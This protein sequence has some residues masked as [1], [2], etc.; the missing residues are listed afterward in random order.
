MAPLT[1]SPQSTSPRLSP[2][3]PPRPTPTTSTS[4]LPPPGLGF[5]TSGPSATGAGRGRKSSLSRN[6]GSVQS[7]RSAISQGLGVQ[8]SALELSDLTPSPKLRGPPS[9]SNSRSH[10]RRSS[11]TSPALQ[12]PLFGF[13]DGLTSPAGLPPTVASA[14]SA[15]RSSSRQPSRRP[16]L[17][18]L[19]SFLS[20]I[21][22]HT[23]V[24]SPGVTGGRGVSRS[25]S[26]SQ[27]RASDGR[28][29]STSTRSSN[30]RESDD[31]PDFDDL[32]DDYGFR[33]SSRRSS[34]TSAR[35]QLHS[36]VRENTT[37]GTGGSDNSPGSTPSALAERLSGALGLTST[38][39]PPPLPPPETRTFRA[40]S[41]PRVLGTS[42]DEEPYLDTAPSSP[43]PY[44]RQ[45]TRT[46][47]SN[48]SYEEEAS[49]MQGIDVFEEGERIGVGVWLE[50]RGGWI[51]DCFDEPGEEPGNGAGGPGVLE[52]ERRL[53]EGTYAM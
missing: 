29:A 28:R 23:R 32:D 49:G 24:R 50:E 26:R 45:R 41:T 16:S 4:P 42:A 21:E 22:H 19:A 47:D 44:F 14:V 18:H 2:S 48:D 30:D 31:E 38:P 6:N 11:I 34:L 43:Q 7:R 3:S 46:L 9:R 5:P 27:S 15:T 37:G 35:S 53:G 33:R 40:L 36:L 12:T 8:F 51:T 52:I 25:A 13:E 10:S 17:S 1:A 39:S 20:G